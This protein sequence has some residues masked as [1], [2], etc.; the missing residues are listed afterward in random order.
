MVNSDIVLC[1]EIK[2]TWSNSFTL[3]GIEFN[4]DLKQ[5]IKNNYESKVQIIKN[6][7]N[8]Y[9]KRNMSILCK[10]TVLKTIIIPKLVYLMKVLPSP[11]TD[12]FA[13]M[14]RCFNNFIWEEK[15]P[16]III[17]QLEKDIAEGGLRLTNLSALNKALKIT[18]IPKV[19]KEEGLWQDLFESSI[20]INR[21]NIWMLDLLSLHNMKSQVKNLFWREVFLAWITYK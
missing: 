7:L 4:T 19:V 11:N 15:G 14:E 3:L 17:S 12:F 21:N 1:P 10:V 20:V 9:K 5:M 13:E 8:S 16:K 2:M 6:T 18:W